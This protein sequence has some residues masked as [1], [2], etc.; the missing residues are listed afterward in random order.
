MSNYSYI[1]L[2]HNCFKIINETELI[3]SVNLAN[4]MSKATFK[5]SLL[6]AATKINWKKVPAA[7][8]SLVGKF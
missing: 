3:T 4:A 1:S 7:V 5:E 6:R 2:V 8:R